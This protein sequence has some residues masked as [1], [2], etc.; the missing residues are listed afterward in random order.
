MIIFL[1]G[2]DTFRS[3]QKLQE[4]VEGYQVKHKSGLNFRQFDWLPDIWA[5]LGNM[6]GSISMFAEKKLIVIKEA[7]L[8]AK[9]DQQKLKELLEKK[10]TEKDEDIILV[11]FESKKPEKGELFDWLAK[12]SEMAQNFEYLSGVK[13]INW[14]KKEVENFGGKILPQAA[15]KLAGSV[16]SDLWQMHNEIEKLVAYKAEDPIGEK[17]IDILVKAKFDPNIFNTIDALASRNKTLVYKLLHQHLSQGESE[18]YIL[19]MFVYQFRNLLQIKSLSEQG[20]QFGALAKKTGLHPFVIKKS[21][22]QIRNFSLEILE[23]IYNRLLKLDIA[24][25]RGKI[26]PKVALDLVVAEITG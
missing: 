5:E 18:I 8:A 19:S 13:L 16:G 12:K 1:Y 2:P 22:P 20:T 25:K 14:I 6:L 9:S 11:F 24:I 10:K 15:E 23:K 4:I 21:W 7:S 17:D 3:R 26:E